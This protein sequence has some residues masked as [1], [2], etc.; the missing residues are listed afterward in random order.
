MARII[1]QLKFCSSYKRGFEGSIVRTEWRGLMRSAYLGDSESGAFESL[2]GLSSYRTEIKP[3]SAPP[4]PADIDRGD[5][6]KLAT[7]LFPD[8]MPAKGS[9]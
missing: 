6:W 3:S 1:Q 2:D 4:P 9:F 8:D 7:E 5:P